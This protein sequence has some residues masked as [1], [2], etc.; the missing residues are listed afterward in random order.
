MECTLCL[1]SLC[2]CEWHRRYYCAF[3]NGIVEIRSDH[4]WLLTID[5]QIQQITILI[6]ARKSDRRQ[7]LKHAAEYALPGTP[8]PAEAEKLVRLIEHQL[9]ELEELLKLMLKNEKS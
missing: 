8:L 2:K 5:K 1:L 3:F 9:K 6:N 7:V 4:F